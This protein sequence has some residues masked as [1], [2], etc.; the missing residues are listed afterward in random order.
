MT[1]PVLSRSRFGSAGAL[2]SVCGPRSALLRRCWANPLH[3]RGVSD[4][5]E[6][7]TIGTTT[8]A[9]RS[10]LK[11]DATQERALS[12]HECV[13][14]ALNLDPAVATPSG[15]RAASREAHQGGSYSRASTGA[16]LCGVPTDRVRAGRARPPRRG[17]S[18]EVVSLEAKPGDLGLLVV[19]ARPT[20]LCVPA[21]SGVD[22]LSGVSSP[23]ATCG[24]GAG[25]AGGF[26]VAVPAR[27][28]SGWSAP[29]AGVYIDSRP[30]SHSIR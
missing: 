13:S 26:Q 20:I 16:L 18:R 5:L 29:A 11:V 3:S 30:S 8:R 4:W 10:L 14:V 27:L 6:P 15:G 1:R 22:G 17:P 21:G 19:V 7:A 12:A 24:Q 25:A 9:G 28:R 23:S 2:R